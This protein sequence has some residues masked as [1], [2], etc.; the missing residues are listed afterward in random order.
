MM[1]RDFPRSMLRNAK[2]SVVGCGICLAKVVFL[3]A[4]DAKSRAGA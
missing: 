1:P 2:K 3:Y 4:G